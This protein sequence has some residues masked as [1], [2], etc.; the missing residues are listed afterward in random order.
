VHNQTRKILIVED[1]AL[2]R[3]LLQAVLRATGYQLL[4]AEDGQRGVDLAYREHPDLI[5]M[6]IMLPVLDGYEATRQLKADPQTR[7]IPIL[8]ITAHFSSLEREH[9][10][11]AGCDGYITKPI[12]T[13]TLPGQ[14]R[15]FVPL[16]T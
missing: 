3:A 15:L 14:I 5:L 1:N 12:N 16:P 11:A 6:D 9:A 13:C 8:A 4:I 7:H 2:N 10:L